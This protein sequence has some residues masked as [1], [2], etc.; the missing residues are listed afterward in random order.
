MLYN[1]V[2]RRHFLVGAGC[3]TLSLPYLVS[4]MPKAHAQGLPS[5]KFLIFMNTPHGG[6]NQEHW[7]PRNFPTGVK[8]QLAVGGLYGT[9]N[10]ASLQDSVGAN[11]LT[12]LW[13]SFITPSLGKMNIIE[14]LDIPFYLGHHRGLLGN[15]HD[16]DQLDPKVIDSTKW[17]SLDYFLSKSRTFD[18]SGNHKLTVLPTGGQ[19]NTAYYNA[20]GANVSFPTAP[21]TAHELFASLFGSATSTVAASTTSPETIKRSSIIDRVLL[22]YRGVSNSAYGAGKRISHND[23]LILDEHISQLRDLEIKIKADVVPPTVSCS[24]LARNSNNVDLRGRDLFDS[25]SEKVKWGI[26]ADIVVNAVRCG[27]SRLFSIPT[28][29]ANTFAVNDFHQEVA[30]QHQTQEVQAKVLSNYR[31]IARDMFGTIVKKL[32]AAQGINGGSVLDQ[33]LVI[34]THESC[35][36]THDNANH[37]VVTAGSAGGYFKTGHHVD[38]RNHSKPMKGV[39]GGDLGFAGIHYNRWLANIAMAMGCSPAEFERNNK[40]GYG[41]HGYEF[42]IGTNSTHAEQMGDFS[43]RLPFITT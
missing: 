1:K 8:K 42:R 32:D 20:S 40:R 5:S 9:I 26:I 22:S 6:L 7:A 36:D 21:T 28:D 24:S 19:S 13:Q 25:T 12:E 30:H 4:L 29:S 17:N 35:K 43:Q 16:S 11:G 38:L 2:N 3:F 15:Y 23:K 37:P 39:W 33:G 18:P 41:P 10:Y 27:S 14:G 34:W 31:N